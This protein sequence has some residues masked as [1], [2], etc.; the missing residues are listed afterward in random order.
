MLVSRSMTSD[1]GV[2]IPFSNNLF[3]APPLRWITFPCCFS[4]SKSAKGWSTGCKIFRLFFFLWCWYC[5]SF[6]RVSE[7]EIEMA[8]TTASILLVQKYFKKLSLLG[9][10]L[11]LSKPLYDFVISV[12]SKFGYDCR[13]CVY[14]K[15][16]FHYTV[17]V[18][19]STLLV[20]WIWNIIYW[21][22]HL[23]PQPTCM[24]FLLYHLWVL[25]HLNY[26]DIKQLSQKGGEGGGGG[27]HRPPRTTP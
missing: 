27:V 19:K 21:G 3:F 7:V 2:F 17:P 25:V 14:C 11:C 8:F 1:D 20:F 6:L 15:V 5:V 18:W 22:P 12:F 13:S 23:C 24:L 16:L 4:R 10:L 9:L 26:R